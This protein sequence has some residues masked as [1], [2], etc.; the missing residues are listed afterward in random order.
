MKLVKL[1]G[2]LEFEDTYR[3]SLRVLRLSGSRSICENAACTTD[4]CSIVYLAYTTDGQLDLA[5][6]YFILGFADKSKRTYLPRERR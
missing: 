5:V 3:Q 4:M 6:K 1:L 2:R